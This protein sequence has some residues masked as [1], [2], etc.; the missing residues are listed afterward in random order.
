MTTAYKLSPSALNLAKECP[1][2]FW[3]T[4]HKVW[5]RPAGIF[6]SLPSGMDKILKIHFD[7]F[8]EKDELPPELC[9]NKECKGM[10]LFKDQ[11]KLKVWQSNF[12]G[13]PYTDKDGNH[14]HGAVDNIL[15]KGKKL[16]VLDYKTRGYPLKEDTAEHYRLQ[17]NTYN[18]LLRKNGYDTEDYFF[19]LFYIP[20]EITKTGEIIFDTELVKMKVDVKMAERAWK[21]ALEM[22]KGKCPKKNSECEWCKHIEI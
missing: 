8:M 10:K 6:P 2:C 11:E 14:L 20:K 1:R 5:K 19:L 17:Q 13:I 18:F 7:K 15:T 16:I 9:N 21:E 12:K 4:Q 22:L 3:L